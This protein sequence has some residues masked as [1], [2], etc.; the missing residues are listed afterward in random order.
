M[1]RV[2]RSESGCWI[3]LG[4]H[5]RGYGRINVGGGVV[6]FTHRVAY[7]LYKGPIP[8]GMQ[9]DHLCRQPACC[10]PDHLEAVTP[11]VNSQRSSAAESVRRRKAAQT[12]CKH[13]HPLTPG[14]LVRHRTGRRFRQCL[15]CARE[16]SRLRNGHRAL[17][18]LRVIVAE[19][20]GGV[21]VLECGHRTA[22]TRGHQNRAC[23]SACEAVAS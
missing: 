15:T 13:G 19:E 2:E 1:A 6:Q 8:T 17:G 9:I 14:N 12:H 3:W 18:P 11:R 21:L 16:R 10:N 4:S 22:R 20:A 23:C 7:E 5:K